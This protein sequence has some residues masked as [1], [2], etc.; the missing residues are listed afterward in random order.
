MRER[1]LVAGLLLF[2][3]LAVVVLLLLQPP[4]PPAPGHLPWQIEPTPGGS[5]TV[6][7]VTLGEDTLREAEQRLGERGALTLF[8]S[9]DGERTVEAYLQR[10]KRGGLQGSIV[11]TFDLPPPEVD[12]IY[13]RGLRIAPTGDGGQK[14]TLAPAARERVRSSPVATLTYLPRTRLDADTVRNRFGE[15]A[16]RLPEP[17][18]GGEHWLY[19]EKGLDLLLRKDGKAVLQYLPPRDFE[20]VRKPLAVISHRAAN[21]S[22]VIV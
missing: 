10:V 22:G 8:I 12:A 11:F 1:H 3:L 13:S 17:G 21:G 5:I 2:S 16:E 7:G 18:G 15:P 4:G 6:F 14:V 20:R 9:A 19:P